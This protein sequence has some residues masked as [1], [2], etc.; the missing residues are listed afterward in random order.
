MGSSV[1]AQE[2]QGTLLFIPS[3]RGYRHTGA[4]VDS[5]QLDDSG[6]VKIGMNTLWLQLTA[7]IPA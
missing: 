3:L 2:A 4:V 7:Y 6:V 1:W 5:S